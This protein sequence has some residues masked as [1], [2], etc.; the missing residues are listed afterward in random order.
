[1]LH[2]LAASGLHVAIISFI[3]LILLGI[4]RIRK[5]LIL[6][7]T[8]LTVFFYLYLTD[9]PV[10]L[11]RAALMLSIYSI[12]HFLDLDKNILNT[13]F[14]TAIAVLL[15]Y[16]F[17]L[18]NIGFQ[19]SFGATLGI[20]IFFKIYKNSISFQP[21]IIS[22]SL[23]LTLSV[24]IFV[25]PIIYIRLNEI[26]LTGL[27]SNVIVVP[28]ISITLIL[29]IVTNFFSL[30]SL[31]AAEFTALITD[32]I[33]NF[34]LIF[35]RQMADVNGHFR[36]EDTHYL[37][38]VAYVLLL[39]PVL[40][41][42]KNKKGIALSI[43]IAFLLAWSWLSDTS[44]LRRNQIVIQKKGK[45]SIMVLS[46][47][48]RAIVYGTLNSY[49]ETKT[50]VDYI[51]TKGINNIKIYIPDMSYRNISNFSYLTRKT[52]VKK[53]YIPSDLIFTS[54][55][56]KFFDIIDTDGII[57]EIKD[58]NR[59]ERDGKNSPCSISN[60]N[61]GPFNASVKELAQLYHFFIEGCSIETR[62]M[63]YLGQTRYFIDNFH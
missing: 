40:P 55:L 8:I 60:Y 35:V 39:L 50:L 45:T 57:L 1:V 47:G 54:Y 46:E 61:I 15:I 7:V 22:K 53:C 2:I 4:F 62:R 32:Y 18:Y 30:I 28:G 5:K 24:L 37:L 20:I 11:M 26:N 44:G 29:S 31:H 6:L 21:S 36:V 17:E 34:C 42:F 13:L 10:S 51:T 23:A 3:P 27:I 9:I 56:E 19:L 59:F 49:E 16:P 41:F 12:Q 14:L 58:F 25:F 33:Y 43:I 38:Y 48:R 52:I 63:I